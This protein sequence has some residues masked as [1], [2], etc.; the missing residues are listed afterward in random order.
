MC[1]PSIFV[2]HNPLPPSLIAVWLSLRVFSCLKF[3]KFALHACGHFA[4]FLLI[5]SIWLRFACNLFTACINILYYNTSRVR[6]M[7]SV[8]LCFWEGN[9]K[10][11]CSVV[12]SKLWYKVAYKTN[13]VFLKQGTAVKAVE[14]AMQYMKMYV[15]GV[16][17]NTAENFF[18]K[19]LIRNKSF[20]FFSAK[21]GAI[22]SAFETKE[23][24]LKNIPIDNRLLF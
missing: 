10:Q 3:K 23:Y 20:D 21:F 14:D 22:Y 11:R 13:T 5:I 15:A 16:S 17:A 19:M 6:F 1:F 24:L 2:E 7:L 4:L 18:K 8:W 12:L 9:H